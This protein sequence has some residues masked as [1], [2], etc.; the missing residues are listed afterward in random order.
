MS[1]ICKICGDYD[2]KKIFSLDLINTDFIREMGT[3]NIDSCSNCGFCCNNIITQEK[4]NDYYEHSNNYTHTLYKE[5]SLNHER[6]GHL[7]DV[8]NKFN[9][10][11][12]DPII[13]LT[14][15]DCSLLDYLQYL[16]YNNLT[17][18][19]ISQENV[20]NSSYTESFKLNIMDINDYQNINK[21]YKFI[22]FNH[23]LEH[24][25]NFDI[26]FD[27]VKI[28]MNNTSLIYIEVPDI[29]RITTDNNNPFLE[30]SYEHI[31]FFNNISLNNLCKKYN[32][33]NIE[34]G[35][36]DFK[37]RI[38]LNIKSVYGLYRI[39]NDCSIIKFKYDNH[40]TES[41]TLYINK[42]IFNSTLI[43][44]QIDNTKTYSIYGM[45]LYALFFLSLYPK[46][47]IHKI[48]DDVKNGV[49]C[50]IEI[51]KVNT[52]DEQNEHL[53]ILSPSY[54]DMLYKN[55]IKHKPNVNILHLHF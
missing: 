3:I 36:L 6:Y 54:Y 44:T 16:G 42:C 45:S 7:K 22:F 55:L 4:C 17:Y 46:L 30:L 43:Y 28:L 10:N 1:N 38:T 50:N 35:L 2:K 20:D 12:N 5:Q 27:N 47:K 19:D 40:V 51:S 24:I 53:L 37:Y 49:V 23:T 41:L 52:I 11:K 34:N 14:S 31:N 48:Y 26:F 25:S 9:I 15:S 8:L 13:D 33:L 18:C 32:L 21:K 29:N 39:D